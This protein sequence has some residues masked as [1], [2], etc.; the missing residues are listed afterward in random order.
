MSAKEEIERLEQKVDI[1]YNVVVELARLTDQEEFT[2]DF[3]SNV[4]NRV[5]AVELTDEELR[6]LGKTKTTKEIQA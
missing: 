4:M 6:N 5:N 2:F 1:L 3:M